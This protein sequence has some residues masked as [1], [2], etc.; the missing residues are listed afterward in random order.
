MRSKRGSAMAERAPL[1]GARRNEPPGA[2]DAMTPS[3]NGR[4]PG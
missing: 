1:D 4:P 3:P 2:E